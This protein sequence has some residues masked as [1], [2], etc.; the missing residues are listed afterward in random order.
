MEDATRITYKELIIGEVDDGFDSLKPYQLLT[1][2]GRLHV[3]K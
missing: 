2:V 1:Q 3:G